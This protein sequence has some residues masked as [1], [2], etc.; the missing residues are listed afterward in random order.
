M[1]NDIIRLSYA[2]LIIAKI[3]ELEGARTRSAKRTEKL[4]SFPNI[5]TCPYYLISEA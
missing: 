5:N 2:D 3:C 4:T 1:L